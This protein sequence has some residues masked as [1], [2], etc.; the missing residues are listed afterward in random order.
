MSIQHA[1]LAEYEVSSSSEC[2][3]KCQ[4]TKCC[5]TTT[6][7]KIIFDD[8][9]KLMCYLH[10]IFYPEQYLQPIPG[11][12]YQHKTSVNGT[13]W[14]GFLK[15]FSEWFNIGICLYIDFVIHLIILLFGNHGFFY[16]L[17]NAIIA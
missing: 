10:D 1:P 4:M 11:A 13:F 5:L 15:K 7:K 2:A 17:A 14:I 3:I 6:I 16:L 8:D 12:Q 9:L